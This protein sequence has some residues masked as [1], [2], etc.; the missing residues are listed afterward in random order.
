MKDTK[1]VGLMVHGCFMVGN[2]GETKDT[3][4]TTLEL[5]KEIN[6]DTAQFFPIMVYPGTEAYEWAKENGY[7]EADDFADWAT[8]EGLHNSVVNTSDLSAR[9]LVEWCDK[10]RREFYLRPSYLAYKVIQVVKR[11]SEFKRN[12]MGFKKLVRYLYQGSFRIGNGRKKKVEL[13]QPVH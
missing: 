10:A 7:I 11:P 6:P 4:D 2:P 8:P 3:L 13:E 1:R 5:A 12:L 9:Q